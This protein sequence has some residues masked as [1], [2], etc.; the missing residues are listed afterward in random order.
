MFLPAVSGATAVENALKLA[1]V[2]QFPERHILALKAGFG[3]KTLFALTG[4]AN[5]S[6]KL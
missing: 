1:L 4:T 6:Y 3:G 5:P 2:A